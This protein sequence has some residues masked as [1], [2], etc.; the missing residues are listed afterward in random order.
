MERWGMSSMA[1]L[2][3]RWVAGM[4][5]GV[6]LST[7]LVQAAAPASASAP[8][9]NATPDPGKGP[10]AYQLGV[11]DRIALSV[12]GEQELTKEYQVGPD[13]FIEL[14][15]I[16]RVRA[17]GRTI[18]ELSAEVRAR[19]ADGFLRNPSVAGSI[20]TFRPFFILGEVNKPGE[21][22]Y[23]EGLTVIAAVAT[24]QGYTYRAQK[25]FVYVRDANASEEV[26]TE[27]TAGLLV[28]PG[29]TIR[30]PQRYF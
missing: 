23:R 12:F 18:N 19:L 3:W 29:Q 10:T 1:R 11:D 27:L 20:I 22:P 24:A 16:G 13:G 9:S 25:R 30:V 28:K 15:L 26:K 6:Y 14:P 7:S 4:L 5:I 17:A 2:M 8:I 21:Y